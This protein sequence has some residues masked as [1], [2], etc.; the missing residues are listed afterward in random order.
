MNRVYLILLLMFSMI[1]FALSA[2]GEDKANASETV[3]VI[4]SLTEI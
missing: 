2:Y 1:A 4:G 3:T